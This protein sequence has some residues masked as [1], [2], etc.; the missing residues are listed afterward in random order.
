MSIY[1]YSAF[2]LACVA[3]AITPGPNMALFIANSAAH[4]TGAAFLTVLGSSFGLAIVV[5]AAALGMSSI[6]AF[7]AEWF[8]IIRWIGAAYLIWLGISR[9][10]AA[11]KAPDPLAAAPLPSRGKWFLQG[12]AASLSNPKVLLFLGAFFPQFIEPSAPIGPQ[13]ALLSVTFVAVIGMVDCMTVLAFGSA[14]E[15][16]MGRRRSLAEGFSGVLLIFGGLWLAAM[17]RT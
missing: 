5:A 3:L 15:W 14:R 1:L 9:L 2:V 11:L 16:M 6:M 7:V 17:R 8:N 12:T 10:R 4:G 13:L